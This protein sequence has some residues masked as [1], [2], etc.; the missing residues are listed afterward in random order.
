[1]KLMAGNSNLPLAR[2]VAAYLETELTHASVRR[3]GMIDANAIRTMTCVPPL[4]RMASII[5]NDI[6]LPRLA[7][8]RG[9][10]ATSGVA[11]SLK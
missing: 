5:R 2:A 9:M 6:N 8:L 10:G 3:F 4:P 1:M 7:A 11:T